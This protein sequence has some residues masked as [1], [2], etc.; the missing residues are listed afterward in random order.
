MF[1]GFVGAQI[2]LDRVHFTWTEISGS[3]WSGSDHVGDYGGIRL[4]NGSSIDMPNGGWPLVFGNYANTFL[5]VCGGS[6]LTFAKNANYFFMKG[7]GSRV[8]VDDSEFSCNVPVYLNNADD[9]S[10]SWTFSGASPRVVASGGLK[11]PGA[12]GATLEFSP[13][14]AGW[15]QAALSVTK[16]VCLDGAAG[17]ATVAVADDAP[18]WKSMKKVDFALIDSADG[19]NTNASRSSRRAARTASSTGIRRTSRARPSCASG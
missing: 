9:G 15:E 8:L 16:D 13:A 6:R 4:D 7:P 17:V 19:I 5:E 3:R 11:L 10:V 1:G 14:K 18:V 2:F 12:G